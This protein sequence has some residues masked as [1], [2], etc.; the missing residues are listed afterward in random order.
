MVGVAVALRGG[1]VTPKGITFDEA[2]IGY[3]QT[4]GQGGCEI[5][6]NFLWAKWI[7]NK[8]YTRHF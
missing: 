4:L 8:C 2:N 7:C 3:D 6:S 1:E 5:S